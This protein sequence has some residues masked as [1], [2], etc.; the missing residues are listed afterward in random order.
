MH[1]RILS[2]LVSNQF[3]VLTR[4]TGLFSRRGFNIRAHG[5]RDRRPAVS[6]H[7]TVL[8]RGETRF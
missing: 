2:M 4:V 8:P 1:Y 6:P 7:S 5:G 3:G